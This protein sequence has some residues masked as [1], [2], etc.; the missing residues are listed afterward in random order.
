MPSRASCLLRLQL[1]TRESSVG[2]LSICGQNEGLFA[3]R[4]KEWTAFA[5][6]SSDTADR[7]SSERE[8]E[9]RPPRLCRSP[10][11]LAVPFSSNKD[12]FPFPSLPGTRD[13]NRRFRSSLPHPCV[14]LCDNMRYFVQAS[15]SLAFS[16]FSTCAA[17]SC[18]SSSAAFA[19]PSGPLH[20]A[21]AAA[22]GSSLP[23]PPRHVPRFRWCQARGA[24]LLRWTPDTAVAHRLETLVE[25]KDFL[26]ACQTW[27]GT[28][29]FSQACSFSC[30]QAK[31]LFSSSS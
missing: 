12:S 5:R 26:L 30:L 17:F 13:E 24:K 22:L 27:Q 1:E 28:F 18:F 20:L 19:S 15:S 10:C 25:A 16:R 14:Q 31:G 2:C 4:E 23:V 8:G 21:V 7:L 11:S 6:R 9:T 3:T 29:C